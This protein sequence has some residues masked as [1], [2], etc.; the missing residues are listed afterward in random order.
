MKCKD[1]YQPVELHSLIRAFI[2]SLYIP[3]YPKIT[4]FN[5]ITAHTPISAQ[6]INSVVFRLQPVYFFSIQANV[7]GTHLNCI[8]LSIQ[9]K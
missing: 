8:N 7:V 9:F 6:S 2:L 1:T 4:I 3:Q 5:L